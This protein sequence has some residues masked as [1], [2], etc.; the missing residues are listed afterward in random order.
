MKPAVSPKPKSTAESVVDFIPYVD[1]ILIM[2]V[3]PGFG[4]QKFMPDML[5]KI[6]EVRRYLDAMNPS[7]DLQLDGG[8]S[9]NN[10]A[11]CSRAGANSFVA[12]TT[13]LR[14]DDMR[15]RVAALRRIADYV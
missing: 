13:L 9:E 3:E 14:A 1:L 12:G 5:P 10:I 2:T 8:I 15:E 7:C 6:S 4:G 11:E